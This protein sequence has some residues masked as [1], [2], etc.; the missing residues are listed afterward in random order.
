MVSEVGLGG[1]WLARHNAEEVKAIIQ[2]A[3]EVGMNIM[4]CFMA[5]PAVRDNIGAA[6][7]GHR[8]KWIIQ[9]H[10]GSTWQDGQYV[11]SR[12]IEKVKEAFEDLLIRY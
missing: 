11:R 5:E 1:E 9:G 4:D 2:R 3:E 6:I 12:E 10:I 8:E 7:R